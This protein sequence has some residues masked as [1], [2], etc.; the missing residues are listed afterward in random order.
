MQIRCLRY[1]ALNFI[2][3]S[4]V[5]YV[6]YQYFV[7]DRSWISPWIKSISNELGSSSAFDDIYVI[8]YDIWIVLSYFIW[9]VPWMQQQA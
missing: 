6:E 3:A 9:E 4:Y 7:H 8:I 1:S 2:Y 5:Y